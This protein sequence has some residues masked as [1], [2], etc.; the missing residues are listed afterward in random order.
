M[1]MLLNFCTVD[2]SGTPA[3]QDYYYL[4]SFPHGNM[5]T[6]WIA[7]EDIKLENEPDSMLYQSLKT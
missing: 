6:A 3:H 7:L 1:L 5:T 4:D 2:L